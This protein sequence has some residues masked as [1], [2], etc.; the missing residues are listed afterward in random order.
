[1]KEFTSLDELKKYVY[2]SLYYKEE[3]FYFLIEDLTVSFIKDKFKDYSNVVLKFEYEDDECFTA[4]RNFFRRREVFVKEIGE[5][6]YAVLFKTKPVPDYVVEEY[7][8]SL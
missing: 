1:M 8:N 2:A 3:C 7:F 4:A 5:K 6:Q